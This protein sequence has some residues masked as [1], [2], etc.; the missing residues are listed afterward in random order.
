MTDIDL[1][2]TAVSDDLG[3]HTRWFEPGGYSS[4]ALCLIDSIYSTGNHYTGVI[5]AVRKYRERRGINASADDTASD[6]ASAV[7]NWG[8]ADALANTTKRWR[9]WPSTKAPYKADAVLRAAEILA[10]HRIE[11]IDDVRERL[12]TPEQQDES[13]AKKEWL[14]LPGQRSGLTWTY[15]L[16][17][18]G[19]PGVK[20]D[21]M[22]VR[23]VSRVLRRDVDPR[24][25][26]RIVSEVA[27]RRNVS[28]TKL[29]HAI[30][31]FESGRAVYIEAERPDHLPGQAH[32]R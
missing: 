3:D 16:M 19:V 26:A 30:W 6:L 4:V 17:L 14:R 13:P 7:K 18:A 29:D 9:C 15:F 10:A 25:A 24:E 28:R 11:T 22:V 5:D 1:L 20:A 8:G 21:R 23:H 32:T 12:G 2:E 27:T 31:R